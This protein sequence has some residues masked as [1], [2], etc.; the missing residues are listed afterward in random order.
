MKYTFSNVFVFNVFLNEL[1]K[2]KQD[3]LAKRVAVEH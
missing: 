1:V 3:D 2:T